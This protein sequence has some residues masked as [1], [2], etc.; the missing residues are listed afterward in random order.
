MLPSLVDQFRAVAG[1]HR[2]D[3]VHRIR[4]DPERQPERIAGLEAFPAAA[5]KLSQFQLSASSLSGGR[6]P[7]TSG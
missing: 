4:G 5:R 1:E 7:G 6:R 3:P 2:A